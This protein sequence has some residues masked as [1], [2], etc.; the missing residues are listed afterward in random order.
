MHGIRPSPS[1][2]T[3][4]PVS[5]ASTPFAA[6]ALL[7]SMRLMRAWAWGERRM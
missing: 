6:F 3:S 7:V 2:S 4:A 1:A 5:T